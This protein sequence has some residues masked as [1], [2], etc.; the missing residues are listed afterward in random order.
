MPGAIPQS[1]G[2][3]LAGHP[4]PLLEGEL[5]I[6]AF[7]LNCLPGDRHRVEPTDRKRAHTV[8]PG[9]GLDNEDRGDLIE[10]WVRHQTRT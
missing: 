9:A 1:A 3:A 10:F 7:R 8:L 5:V 2:G 6:R 4:S